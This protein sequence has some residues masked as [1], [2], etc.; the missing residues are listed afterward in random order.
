MSV[1]IKVQI[2]IQ[3][4]AQSVAPDIIGLSKTAFIIRRY[5]RSV[6]EKGSSYTH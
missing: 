2:V 3:H 1:W 6:Q 4:Y 5:D